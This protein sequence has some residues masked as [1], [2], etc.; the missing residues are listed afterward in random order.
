MTMRYLAKDLFEDV[1]PFVGEYGQ[2]TGNAVEILKYLD[3]VSELL[4][5]RGDWKGTIEYGCISVTDCCF[6]LPWHLEEVRNAWYCNQTIPVH[7]QYY[8]T[9][10]HVGIESC[11]GGCCMPQLTQTGEY[12]PYQKKAPTGWRIAVQGTEEE[13][14]TLEFQMF[15]QSGQ[16]HIRQITPNL[17]VQRLD[18]NLGEL[19]AVRKPRTKGFVRLLAWHPDH[20]NL[21]FVAKYDAHQE[22]PDFS[23]YKL[24]GVPK[25]QNCPAL[26]IRAKKK[27]IP[28]RSENDVI[29][30]ESKAALEFACLALNAKGAK[31][32]DLYAQN[33]NL[34]EEQL[35]EVLENQLPKAWAPLTVK[36]ERQAPSPQSLGRMPWLRRSR[37]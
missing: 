11:C 28:I 27:Y 33:L 19:T 10:S 7:D 31:K 20:K 6:G 18:V 29:W 8:Q 1:A 25:R 36:Y 32:N 26:I 2:C 13:E 4:W 35:E 12:W 37:L 22:G 30:L 15:D 17:E 3:K 5:V 34:A 21:E 23:H 14:V 16:R 9:M 24:T